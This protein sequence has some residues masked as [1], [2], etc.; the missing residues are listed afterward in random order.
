[1]VTVP[2][3]L[4][5]AAALVP[6]VVAA[7]CALPATR[8]LARRML[9]FAAL[10]ALAAAVLVPE[11]TAEIDWLFIGTFVDF[12]ATGRAF[13]ALSGV[14]WTA[15]ALYLAA[16][17]PDR[18]TWFSGW[19]ALA[20]AGNLALCCVTDPAAFYTFFA[21]MALPTYALV[22]HEGDRSAGR[23][24][25]AFTVVGEALLVCGL[26]VVGATALG[27]DSGPVLGPAGIGLVLAAFGVKIG[28]LGLHGWM[29]VSYAAAPTV[30]AAALAGSMSK[31]GV[32]GLIRFLPAGEPTG[33][34]F[35][36]PVIA[37]GV[38]AAFYGAVVGVVQVKP[39]VVLAYSSISQFGLITVALGV[40]LAE[41]VA[42]LFAVS[43]ATVY[44]VHHG[45][46]KAALFIGEDIAL[47]AR[48]RWL[49]VA[50]LALPALALAGAPLASGAVAKLVLK[51][52]TA[53]APGVWHDA[54][55]T[56]LPLAAVGTTL[57]MA[58][59]LYLVATRSLSEPAETRSEAPGTPAILSWTLLLVAVAGALWVWPM[60]DVGYAA[61]KS[62]DAHY[63]WLAAWPVLLG[64]VAAAATWAVGD[65]T[66]RLEGVIPPADVYAPL[67]RRADRAVERRDRAVRQTPAPQAVTQPPATMNR[68]ARLLDRAGVV[69]N[70][71]LAWAT[72]ASAIGA[73]TVLLL[74]L[75]ARG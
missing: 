53:L 31:A 74:L 68:G 16:H 7:G 9:V 15:A 19:F 61:Q 13:L 17:P 37:F 26:F 22:A 58:R 38:A 71:F 33:I 69:E 29:P 52:A 28:A 30:A 32:L 8:D 11:G 43:A 51:E 6:L 20:M 73:L 41:P 65:R 46:A 47:R 72:A 25:M 62:L 54:L 36:G 48:R 4:A 59:F 14:I 49:A 45:L 44:S 2:V 60:T 66:R 12:D 57:L 64:V 56:L 34:P 5:L 70:G 67:L 10:P 18:P 50:G 75:A 42:W 21:M 39:K 63:L 55:E 27:I 24:Y 23:A 1:M 35:G 40:G 3:W